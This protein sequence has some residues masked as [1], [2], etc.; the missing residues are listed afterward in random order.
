MT[1]IRDWT[2]FA[3]MVV[4][5]I[6][7]AGAFVWATDI[8]EAGQAQQRRPVVL[9]TTPPAAIVQAQ[10]AAD[11]GNAFASVAEVVRPTVV[12]IRSESGPRGQ[13]RPQTPFDFFGGPQQGQPRS[14]SGSG[15]IIS[16]DGYIITNNHV[17]EEAD[18]ITVRLLDRRE[19]VAEVIGTDPNTDIA[20][21]KIDAEDL[22]A[23]SMGNSDDVRIGEWALAI[24][25]PLGEAFSFSVTAGIVSAKGRALEGLERPQYS[26]HD[27]IQTDAAINPGNSGGPLV[28][29][30]GQVI[31]VNTAIASRTGLYTGYGFAVPINMA[32]R[33]GEQLIADGHV[34]RAIL[35]VTIED[36]SAEDAEYV[37]LD[38]IFGVRV[39]DFSGDDSPARQGGLKPGDIIIELDGEHVSYV[40]QLQQMIG[41][42]RPGERVRIRVA[43]PGGERTNVA[44]VLGQAQEQTQPVARAETPHED[45][46]NSF[47]E[48]LG[49]STQTVT[50][51]R[52]AREGLPREYAGL[53]IVEVDP[54]GPARGRLNQGWIITHVED[55]RV[56][57]I[58]DL[59]E[60][61]QGV[62]SGGI[63]SV[64]WVA[65]QRDG[66]AV[67]GIER[68][69]TK[70]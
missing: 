26:I 3:F 62:R 33:V 44:V 55:N 17:V 30:Q 14:G 12:F 43:R 65:F 20:I 32:R 54:F 63:V 50:G 60:A 51:D 53:R 41:F 61:L 9:N 68:I 40:A 7:L 31:G 19:F 42:K 39:Q 37:G 5:T 21:I 64:R 35:G 58:D 8:T 2:K 69:R 29:I 45:P 36:A 70:Q 67:G 13:T 38:S 66:S 15:F 18:R 52:L 28:N 49:I 22:T 27:F 1:G 11:L 57:S 47:E 25:N 10:P 46:E 6:V 59:Q 23:A 56:E 24:G 4:V 16:E 48:A 34:T